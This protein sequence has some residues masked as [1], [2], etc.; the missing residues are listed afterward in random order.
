M[1]GLWAR[2]HHRKSWVGNLVSC[3]VQ[4][5]C[6]GCGVLMECELTVSK[7]LVFIGKSKPIT[8]RKY[9]SQIPHTDELT[10]KVAV[11]V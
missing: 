4:Y 1:C 3:L 7:L 9:I 5:V 6:V 8:F 11:W 2:I 10:H